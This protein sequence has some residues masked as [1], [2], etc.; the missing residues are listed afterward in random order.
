M[1]CT[2]CR[3]SAFA[4]HEVATRC[5]F[6]VGYNKSLA[7]LSISYNLLTDSFVYTVVALLPSL[8]QYRPRW[9][10]NGALLRRRSLSCVAPTVQVVSFLPQYQ[11]RRHATAS[12]LRDRSS[13]CCKQPRSWRRFSEAFKLHPQGMVLLGGGRGEHFALL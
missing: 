13:S 6:D 12:G 11:H 8:L 10:F 9:W 5:L 2:C 4:G 1:S 3:A 7:L